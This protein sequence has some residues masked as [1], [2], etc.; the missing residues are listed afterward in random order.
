MTSQSKTFIELSDISALHFEC[1]NPDCKATLTVSTS[2][3]LREKKLY[4]CPACEQSWGL[5]NGSSCVFT[6]KEFLVVLKKLQDELHSFPAGF[7]LNVE[8]KD[9]MVPTDRITR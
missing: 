3:V 6:I 8:V 4:N 2:Q 7:A 1:K 5:V 9:V